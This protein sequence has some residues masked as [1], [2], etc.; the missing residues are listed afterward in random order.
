MYIT[1]E[2]FINE[3]NERK[4]TLYHGTCLE[5]AKKLIK[6]GW[7]PR[8]GCSGSNCSLLL[9]FRRCSSQR[10]RPLCRGMERMSACS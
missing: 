9:W 6:N 8:S 2:S 4:L 5:N 1:L 3:N 10:L 7:S